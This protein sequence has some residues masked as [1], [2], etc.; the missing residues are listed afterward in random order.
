MRYWITAHL[1]LSAHHS[2]WNSD[3]K[4]G[5]KTPREEFRH[6]GIN[7]TVIWVQCDSET[8]YHRIVSRGEIRDQW[9]L[10]HWAEYEKSLSWTPEPAIID[11][12]IDNTRD[13]VS[14]LKE[15]GAIIATQIAYRQ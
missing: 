4:T 13:A 12:F 8:N 9:K 7:L 2:S 11:Y 10:D 6:R 5:V 3:P 14:S 1:L 15:Q